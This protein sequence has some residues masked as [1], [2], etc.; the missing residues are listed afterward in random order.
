MAELADAVQSPVPP[1]DDQ[2]TQN[3]K[4]VYDAASKKLDL[5]TFDDFKTNLDNPKVVQGLYNHITKVEK[6]DVGSL[7]DFSS[8]TKADLAAARA[9]NAQATFTDAAQ[10]STK[11]INGTNPSV[12]TSQGNRQYQTDDQKISDKL[13]YQTAGYNSLNKISDQP[14]APKQASIRASNVPSMASHVLRSVDLNVLRPLARAATDMTAGTLHGITQLDKDGINYVTGGLLGTDKTD[15]FSDAQDYVD[16]KLPSGPSGGSATDILRSAVQTAPL[17]LSTL[18]GGEITQVPKALSFIGAIGGENMALAIPKAL[19]IAG[20]LGGTA[21]FSTYGSSR[22]NGDDIGTAAKKGLTAGAEGAASGLAMEGQSYLGGQLGGKL[23]SKLEQQGLIQGGKLLPAAIK[24]MSTMSVFGAGSAAEDIARGHDVD[25]HNVAV[26]MGVGAAFEVPGVGSAAT[27]DISALFRAKQVSRMVS[28]LKATPEQI[29][30]I[31]AIPTSPVDM[32]AHAIKLAVDAGNSHDAD[33]SNTK[34]AAA[35]AL[36]NAADIKGLTHDIVDNH[37][38][39]LESIEKSDLE[40]EEKQALSQRVT[41]IAE[42]H[43]PIAQK[44]HELSSGIQQSEPKIDALNQAIST[45]KDP[46][47]KSKLQVEQEELKTKQSDDSKSLFNITKGEKSGDITHDSGEI[48]GADKE[49]NYEPMTKGSKVKF[50]GDDGLPTEG[51]IK[52]KDKSGSHVIEDKDGDFVVRAKDQVGDEYVNGKVKEAEEKQ[53]AAVDKAGP[54]AD[55]EAKAEQKK[56]ETPEEQAK[57]DEQKQLEAVD[58]NPEEKQVVLNNSSKDYTPKEYVSMEDSKQMFHD[59]VK[60]FRGEAKKVLTRYKSALEKKVNSLE[61]AL[62]RQETKFS[63][64]LDKNQAAHEAE[65]DKIKNKGERKDA[66]VARANDIIISDMSDKIHSLMGTVE[67]TQQDYESKIGKD[68]KKNADIISR[69]TKQH[70]AYEAEVHQVHEDMTKAKADL[71]D[72]VKD[73]TEKIGKNAPAS[74]KKLI[75]EISKIVSSV[76]DEKSLAKAITKI[77]ARIEEIY[78]NEGEQAALRA[79]KKLAEVSKRFSKVDPSVSAALKMLSDIGRTPDL[80]SDPHGYAELV[81]GKGTKPDREA[82]DEVGKSETRDIKLKQGVLDAKGNL[83]A[84]TYSIHKYVDAELNHA[85]SVKTERAIDAIQKQMDTMRAE[86][87]KAG[88]DSIPQD[89]SARDLFLDPDEYA[90]Y[91][92]EEPEERVAAEIVSKPNISDVLTKMIQAAQEMMKGFDALSPEQVV[93]LDALRNIKVDGEFSKVSDEDKRLINFALHNV[94]ANGKG[95]ILNGTDAMVQYHLHNVD[96]DQLEPARKAAEKHFWNWNLGIAKIKNVDGVEAENAGIFYMRKSKLTARQT[97]KALNSDRTYHQLLHQKFTEPIQRGVEKAS[98][99][100]E[101]ILKPIRENNKEKHLNITPEDGI[102]VG[103]YNTLRQFNWSSHLDGEDQFQAY[104]DIIRKS[105]VLMEQ[106]LDVNN[107]FRRNNEWVKQFHMLKDT[108]LYDLFVNRHEDIQSD[109]FGELIGIQDK[110]RELVR[111][112][113]EV[114]A[115]NEPLVQRTYQKYG[116]KPDDIENY[117]HM[118]YISAG[119]EKRTQGLANKDLLAEAEGQFSQSEGMTSLGRHT[120]SREKIPTLPGGEVPTHFLNLDA[121]SSFSQGLNKHLM[122]AF[123]ISE[124]MRLQANLADDRAHMLFDGNMANVKEG[125]SNTAH[126]RE[127][128]KQNVGDAIG[129]SG[130]SQNSR[131]TFLDT[132]SLITMI[133]RVPGNIFYKATLG[134]VLQ[135]PKQY[136]ESFASAAPIIGDSAAQAFG[137]NFKRFNEGGAYDMLRLK[138]IDNGNQLLSRMSDLE[139]EHTQH[140]ADAYAHTRTGY[141]GMLSNK[142]MD[143][144]KNYSDNTMNPLKRGD[145]SISIDTWVSAYVKNLKETGIIQDYSE[146]N[147]DFIKSHTLDPDSSTYADGLV[148]QTNAQVSKSF[149]A[150]TLKF[151]GTERLA[152]FKQFLSRFQTFQIHANMEARIASR[153]MFH[154]LN[155]GKNWRVLAGYAGSQIASAAFKTYVANSLFNL[156]GNGLIKL[157]LGSDAFDKLKQKQFDDEVKKGRFLQK[158]SNGNPMKDSKGKQILT[159]QRFDEWQKWT[160]LGIDNPRQL[161]SWTLQFGE[162]VFIGSQNM[163]VQA[164]AEWSIDK[165]YQTLIIRNMNDPDQIAAMPKSIFH[166]TD[167]ILGYGTYSKLLDLGVFS[168]VGG[169]GHKS[170]FEQMGAVASAADK[171]K[172]LLSQLT[173]SFGGLF[174]GADAGAI[175]QRYNNG[176]QQ[177]MASADH[178]L[179][180]YYGVAKRLSQATG[181]TIASA[182]SK[183]KNT[184]F[185]THDNQHINIYTD[186]QLIPTV[187]KIY[188]QDLS[189]RLAK[190]KVM[191]NLKGEKM[192]DLQKVVH[193]AEKASYSYALNKAM[194][195]KYPGFKEEHKTNIDRNAVVRDDE[196]AE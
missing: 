41:D 133:A 48:I 100:I 193:K 9:N 115:L 113:D 10:G 167:N 37:Q 122:T 15:V 23:V 144:F 81:T 3:L 116:V 44:K 21:G 137:Y 123:T 136:L 185:T 181:V 112:M 78:K 192:G 182:A 106:S 152:D 124:R 98:A 51:E 17:I 139:A 30:G 84:S 77:E 179:P 6:Y 27:D 107:R 96:Q 171:R 164:G 126:I 7:Q 170:L 13:N 118:D 47:A 82:Q 157:L 117:T 159:H 149:M 169:D 166:S 94:I 160:G 65:I 26:N 188:A 1:G 38:Q 55:V 35:T 72:T 76:H 129:T 176:V 42:T 5:G 109:N 93:A 104:K 190:L 155:D 73:L 148:E 83:T 40:P 114:H 128:I 151:D 101:L 62:G 31:N 34:I 131:H 130:K 53:S 11:G 184:N 195:K 52:G 183:M 172:L 127:L 14:I 180:E 20:I 63:S 146:F 161:L 99:R 143:F 125:N 24:A 103:I 54:A 64:K 91:F 33:E 87:E 60:G 67:S 140:M 111:Q 108:G 57:P 175:M 22:T 153:N 79:S 154:G 173:T 145:A 66:K 163:V 121:M 102:R 147:A 25:W 56:S 8:Q 61:K 89:V 68:A 32:Q 194:L 12:L 18:I 74:V 97:F 58:S 29:D 43:N 90:V 88:M 45:E 189:V 150:S 36:Q 4:S 142:A 16:S 187:D 165:M 191:E 95:A 28:L 141:A 186:K 70:Q 178:K 174:M 2:A 110:H 49:N 19:K 135:Q 162:N 132:A 120:V 177:I 46:I 69:V 134:S 85:E 80:L 71:L 158:D 92:G 86:D 138:W 50:I 39:V 75:P 196:P 156:A 168:Y 59:T 119:V 105:I